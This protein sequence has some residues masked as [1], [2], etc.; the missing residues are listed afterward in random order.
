[1]DVNFSTAL[2]QRCRNAQTHKEPDNCGAQTDAGDNGNDRGLW[3]V[4]HLY[5]EPL[6]EDQLKSLEMGVIP[7]TDTQA[8]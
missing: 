3:Q 5:C 6:S 1:M 8:Y 7:G 2:F 4:Q